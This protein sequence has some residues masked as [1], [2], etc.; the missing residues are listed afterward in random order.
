MRRVPLAMLALVTLLGLTPLGL[1]PARAQ[2][3]EVPAAFAPF[4]HL[5]GAWKGAGIPTA[6]KVKGWPETHAW[7]WA[8]EGGKPVA[9]S[10]ELQGNKALKSGRLTFDADAKQYR[11]DAQDAEAKPAVYTGTLDAAGQ[12][13]TLDREGT[14]PDGSKQR[15]TVRLNSNKIRYL[16][17]D[18]R[19]TK[20]APRFSRFIEVNQGKQGESF[21]A[22]GATSNLPKCIITG[23]AATM[24][25]SHAGKSYP[26][27]CTGCRDEFAA[28]PEKYIAKLAQKA[29]ASGAAEA[30]PAPAASKVQRDDGSFDSLVT[31]KRALP[32]NAPKPSTKPAR[33]EAPTTKAAPKSAKTSADQ[34][35]EL[36]TKAQAVEAKGATAA[37]T[38]FYKLIVRQHPG[39]PQARTAA[40][41]LKTLGGQ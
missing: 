41:R 37:A 6:N 21:A 29:A 22:G 20:G 36:L 2:S 26:I 28:D 31:D 10:L 34:A 14:L 25:V 35:A 39:T 16:V 5:I 1:S 40:E 8:F 17:W 4:E 27:C 18:D 11:L 19:Q 30:A 9:I 15:L 38:A 32:K 33:S 24:T 7:A 13:L 12:V 23:G 3:D